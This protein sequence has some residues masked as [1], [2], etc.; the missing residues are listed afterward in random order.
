MSTSASREDRPLML[1]PF[2]VM[3]NLYTVFSVDQN[4]VGF[5]PLS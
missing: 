4:A 5:A 3:Q 2:S 1:V